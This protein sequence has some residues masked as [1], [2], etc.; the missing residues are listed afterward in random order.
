MQIPTSTLGLAGA[1]ALLCACA[2]NGDG[3]NSQGEPGTPGSTPTQLTADFQSIQDNVFTPICTRC[4]EGASAP[5][6]LQLDAAHSYALLVGVPSSEVPTLTRVKPGDPDDSYIILKLEGASGIVGQQM[7]Y[8]GPYLPSST[9]DVIR[10][11]IA[12]G[13]PQSSPAAAAAAFAVVA[14]SPADAAVLPAAPRTLVVA[15]NRE[16]D[17]SLLNSGSVMLERDTAEGPLTVPV[18]IGAAPGNPSTVLLSPLQTLGVGSYRLRVR[19]TGPAPIADLS[20][21]GLGIDTTAQFR[22]AGEP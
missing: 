9:I 13:A 6:G 17:Q 21:Q 18:A 8:G 20:A 5:E 14:T 11:W 7:P 10:S 4:H 12:S 22:V 1:T 16:V 2:G 15:F 19:G 3:L